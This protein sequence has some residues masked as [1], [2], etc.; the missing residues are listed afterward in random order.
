MLTDTMTT[1]TRDTGL[2]DLMLV[3]AIRS[4]VLMQ[5]PGLA[6]AL[7]IDGERPRVLLSRSS[8]PPITL[9]RAPDGWRIDGGHGPVHLPG[10]DADGLADALLLVHDASAFGAEGSPRR[11][12][13]KGAR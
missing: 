13:W 7:R 6:A 1:T 12:R 5:R 11:A 8:G 10:T 9:T 2:A 4:R 3:Y